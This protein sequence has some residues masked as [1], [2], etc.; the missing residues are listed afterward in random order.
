MKDIN[1]EQLWADAPTAVLLGA[2]HAHL[3]ASPA[4][5]RYAGASSPGIRATAEGPQESLR[6]RPPLEMLGKSVTC[7][8]WV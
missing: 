7:F 5:G 4:R 8:N 2:S 1:S 6:A 3:A